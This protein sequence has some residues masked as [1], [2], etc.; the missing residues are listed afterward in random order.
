MVYVFTKRLMYFL[1]MVTTLIG[2]IGRLVPSVLRSH[3]HHP[4]IV[5]CNTTR[6]VHSFEVPLQQL[7]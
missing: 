3:H 7:T 6:M 5:G 4:R 1:F 2:A